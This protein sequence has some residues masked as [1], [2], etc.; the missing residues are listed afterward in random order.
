MK[1]TDKM[2]N[3]I[4]ILLFAAF[5][6]YAAVYAIHAVRDTT[7]TADAVSADVTLGG[8]ATGIV[9]RKE[10]VLTSGEKF[11]DITAKDGS[12]VAAGTP[13][14]TAMRSEAGLDRAARMHELELEIS[15]ISAALKELDS[16]SDLTTRDEAL[17]SA[18]DNIT[19]S[20]ARHELDHIDSLSLNLRSL[21]FSANAS[22]ASE[23]ELS[24]LLSE[25]DSM[26]NSSSSEASVLT[27]QNSG[28]FST[29]IDGYENLSDDNLSGISPSSLEKMIDNPG[30]IPSGAFGKLILSYQWYFAAVMDVDDA[31][32]LTVG[33]TATLNF[34]RY[35][36]SNIGTRVVS[37]SAPENERVAVV[38][39]CS[40]ALS[41]TLSMR[42]VSANV[43]Y[44]EY[45]G[46]RVPVQAL[47]TDSES[48]EQFVWVITAMQLER[49]PVNVLYY[50]DDFAIISR[51][52][53]V[54]SLREGNTVVVT[55]KSLYEGKIME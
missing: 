44:E 43:V 36:G 37:I 13:L 24:A 39:R 41:D 4:A 17:R 34:G 42:C 3:F 38:F 45:S 50:D 33:K 53:S 11:I 49:K 25:L 15:R 20:V 55:G 5:A 26:K 8:L 6:V 12:K 2:T 7:V 27:A 18:V 31:S 23:E 29:L 10:V 47:H 46:I 1:R 22:G 48:N 28:Y 14:A 9:I 30:A 52:V 54:N 51:D 19:S 16:A 35:Y 40:S 21:L 32:N